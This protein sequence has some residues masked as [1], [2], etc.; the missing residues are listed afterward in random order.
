MIA[1]E[2]TDV[3]P[4]AVGIGTTTLVPSPVMVR[5]EFAGITSGRLVPPVEGGKPEIEAEMEFDVGVA[6]VESSGRPV[7]G[8]LMPGA[9]GE[10]FGFKVERAAGRPPVPVMVGRIES[11]LPRMPLLLFVSR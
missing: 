6:E 11:A 1:G 7:P 9:R 10:L 4:V 3:P 5:T 2:A 8:P